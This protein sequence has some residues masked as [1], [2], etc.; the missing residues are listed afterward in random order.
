[1]ATLCILGKA[2]ALDLDR[3]LH[4]AVERQMGFEGGFQGRTAKRVDSC[5]SFWQVK[6]VDS[7]FVSSLVLAAFCTEMQPHDGDVG[8]GCVFL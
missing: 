6:S 8:N 7:L 2:D 3:L 5:Y 4:W 1:M